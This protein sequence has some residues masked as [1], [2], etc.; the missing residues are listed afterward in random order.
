MDRV[1]LSG[2]G[3]GTVPR[4]PRS[5]R[6]LVV[7]TTVVSRFAWARSEALCPYCGLPIDA[8]DADEELREPGTARAVG[9]IV[10]HRRCGATV[11]LRFA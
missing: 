4:S 1:P 2:V 9:A 11:R 6:C 8:R 10:T 3:Q 5:Y 7:E